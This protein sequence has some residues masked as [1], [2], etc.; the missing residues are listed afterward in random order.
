MG[1]LS[2]IPFLSIGSG[3][4]G[5]SVS[6][7]LITIMLALWALI[8]MILHPL[9]A[10]LFVIA[11]T[12]EYAL[13]Y[14]FGFHIWFNLISFFVTYI[15]IFA[16]YTLFLRRFLPLPKTEIELLIKLSQMKNDGLLDDEE[17]K[18]AKKKLLKL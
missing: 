2:S 6:L 15:L 4:F 3:V 9:H 11:G 5:L 17:F 16:F 10:T 18:K 14:F 1:F 8:L 12:V 7:L 13:I